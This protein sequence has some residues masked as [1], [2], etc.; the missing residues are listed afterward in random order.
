MNIAGPSRELPMPNVTRLSSLAQAHATLLHCW[1]K[2]SRFMQ[3]AN[4]LAS[5]GSS[6][7]AQRRTALIDERR[8]FQQWLNQWETAFTAFLSSAVASMTTEDIT[9]SRVL[10]TNHLA[11]TVL[12][13]DDPPSFESE[14][15]AIVDL[16]GAVLRSRQ[17]LASGASPRSNTSTASDSSSASLRGLDVREPLIVLLG[18]CRQEPIRGRARELLNRFYGGDGA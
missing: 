15:Q 9:Q 18:R 7:A 13:S 10:K 3:E 2:L 17:Q 11:C 14:F 4:S 1:T 5:V 6:A 16:S 8:H 12:A